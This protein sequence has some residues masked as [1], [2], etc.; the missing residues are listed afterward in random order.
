MLFRSVATDSSL[1]TVSTWQRIVYGDAAALASRSLGWF[2]A[3]RRFI[4]SPALLQARAEVPGCGERGTYR[5]APLPASLTAITGLMS[6]SR[7]FLMSAS[8][9]GKLTRGHH[10]P[11][12]ASPLRLVRPVLASVVPPKVAGQGYRARLFA[13]GYRDARSSASG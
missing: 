6:A 5:L 3:D 8:I 12:A 9:R 11:A 10:R 7:E 13:T 2:G 4:G 1:L